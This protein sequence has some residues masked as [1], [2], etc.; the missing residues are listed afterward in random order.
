MLEFAE[1]LLANAQ[2]QYLVAVL[3]LYFMM[4][5]VALGLYKCF[6]RPMV[7]DIARVVRGVQRGTIRRTAAAK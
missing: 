4:L 6:V 3:G 5:A 2:T 7:K 1:M